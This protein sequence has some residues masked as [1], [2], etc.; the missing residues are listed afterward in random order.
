[1]FMH[2]SKRY[3]I[4]GTGGRASMYVRYLAGEGREQGHQLVG[5]CDTNPGRMAYY[6]RELVEKFGCSLMLMEFSMLTK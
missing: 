5:F 2:N 1:M 3:L 4:V 6:N